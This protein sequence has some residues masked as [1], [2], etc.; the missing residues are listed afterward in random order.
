MNTAQ[1]NGVWYAFTHSFLKTIEYPMAATSLTKK[2]WEDILKPVLKQLLPK[3]RYSSK[4]PRAVLYGPTYYQGL[5]IPHL[6]YKQEIT[7]FQTMGEEILNNT[8]TGNLI[9]TLLEALLLEAG[10]ARIFQAKQTAHN[11]CVSS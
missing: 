1:K 9:L 7:R 2:D 6:W 11:Y 10:V 8:T 5:G 4:F 3:A